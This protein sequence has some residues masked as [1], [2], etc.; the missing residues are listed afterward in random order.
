MARLGAGEAYDAI[1]VGGS[2]A[3]SSIAY[4]LVCQ[5]VKTLKNSKLIS[6]LVEINSTILS[7]INRPQTLTVPCS[8][9]PVPCSHKFYPVQPR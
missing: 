4:R 8:L 7:Y 6:R 5:G 1:V 9:F 2:I 3:D